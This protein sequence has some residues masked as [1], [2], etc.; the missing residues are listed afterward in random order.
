MIISYLQL[1]PN[2][3]TMQN[4]FGETPLHML[5]SVTYFSDASGGAIKAYL[6]SEE[7]RIAAF[8]KDYKGRTP[9]DRLCEKSIDDMLLST[10]ESFG[11]LMV[12]WYDCLG[13][14]IFAEDVICVTS[15]I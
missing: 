1:A 13:I 12:W 4:N 2:V 6:D 10:N 15:K 5:C 9:F 3:A 8:M 7:G 14:G 11:G